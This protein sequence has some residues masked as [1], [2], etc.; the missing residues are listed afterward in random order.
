MRRPAEVALAGQMT[1][2]GLPLAAG[3]MLDQPAALMHEIDLCARVERAYTGHSRAG[4]GKAA[5]L[6]EHPYDAD[7]IGWCEAYLS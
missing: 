3:G 7:V 4:V 2:N 1:R 6:S 5:W